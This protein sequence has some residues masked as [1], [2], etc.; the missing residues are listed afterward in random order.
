MKATC[1]MGRNTVE[2]RNVPDPGIVNARDAVVRVTSTAIC[3]SDLHLYDG[4]VP[5][6]KKG[7]ILGHE[8][9][10]EVVE[11][12]PQVRNLRVGDRV[13]VPFPI[14]CG[15][16]LSCQNGM[17]SVCE[18]SNPNAGVAERLMGHSPAG[19]F[20]YSHM[21]GG[22]AGGQ[23]EYARVPFADVGPI[24][25]EDGLPD[26]KVLFLSDIL[27]T[28]WMGAEMCDIKPG[29]VI[30][31]WGAGPV[32]QLAAVSARLMGAERVICIDRLPYRLHHAERAGAETLNYEE[33]DV[34]EALQD[35]TAGRGPDACID[36]V[37]MEAHHGN[38]AMYAYDRTKQATRLETDR[39]YALRQAIL[40]CRNGGTVS[41]IGVYGGFVDKF[42]M[43]AIMNRS[44]TLR[45]GQ[46]H[47]QR[48]M[49]P[50][51]DRIRHGDIDPSFVISHRMR[52]EDA[53]HA[54][55]MFKNKENECNKV[56]LTT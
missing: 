2:V 9:M 41:V 50:L 34:L 17:Y 15:N 22:Y 54:Y 45:A 14:A 47:V 19:I 55:E 11:V 46:C 28:G 56:V 7:D 52:L 29:D 8:F 31:I 4:Y 30:A 36:A 33:V 37:G 39:P 1:W 21:L 53:P 10:G 44:L 13:V 5:T 18:N 24:K 38:P 27:P 40:A 26:E 20:G 23:A 35:M 12:G 48:Y 25:V 43:G 42:P 51:M 3:G 49:R 6:M 32:G 16:C